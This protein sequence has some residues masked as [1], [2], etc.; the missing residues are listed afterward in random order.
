MATIY[1]RKR[2]VFNRLSYNYVS[3]YN[4]Y[5][6]H[7]G[8]SE[9]FLVHIENP[10][11]PN[12]EESLAERVTV[13]D[14]YIEMPKEAY[15]DIAHPPI[16]LFNDTILTD[17]DYSYSPY[18]KQVKLSAHIKPTEDDRLDL[19]YYKDAIVYEHY[20]LRQSDTSPAK[21]AKYRVE[22]VFRNTHKLGTHNTI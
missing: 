19:V 12:L 6:I 13:K 7:E 3:G 17:L 22:T 20:V 15:H 16:V 4:I 8:E 11:L 14:G 10:S 21:R 18:L 9:K 5:S 1:E 2:L